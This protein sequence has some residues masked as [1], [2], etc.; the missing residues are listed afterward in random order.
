MQCLYLTSYQ[1]IYIY[2]YKYNM[3]NVNQYGF[4]LRINNMYAIKK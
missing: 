2:I 4:I 3:L 1:S